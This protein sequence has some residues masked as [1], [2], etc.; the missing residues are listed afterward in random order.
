M[1]MYYVPLPNL[2][3]VYA[4]QPFPRNDT[5]K[6]STETHCSGH[7]QGR[8]EPKMGPGSAQILRISG[9]VQ[10]KTAEENGTIFSGFLCGL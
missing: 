7:T 4:T 2:Q 9:F 1:F 3:C 8:L 10:S 6:N 5:R